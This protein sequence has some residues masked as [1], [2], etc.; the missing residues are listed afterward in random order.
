[1]LLGLEG[2][3]ELK[4]M[5]LIQKAK[6][7]V[8]L[9]RSLLLLWVL[10]RSQRGWGSANPNKCYEFLFSWVL[11]FFFNVFKQLQKWVA[12]EQRLELPQIYLNV[13][14]DANNACLMTRWVVF[15]GGCSYCLCI[16]SAGRL[17]VI[18]TAHCSGW[19][20]ELYVNIMYV[21]LYVFYYTHTYTRSPLL[22][23]L[24]SSILNSVAKVAIRQVSC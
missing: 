3:L 19:V 17:L 21:C 8:E 22:S 5:G 13:G 4:G 16:D 24:L 11:G 15:K 14:G 2:F 23:P 6:K 10:N 12:L 1:M 9:C 18:L 20:S 7:F